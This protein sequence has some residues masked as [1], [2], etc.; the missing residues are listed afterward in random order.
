MRIILI[1]PPG[2]G[3]GTQAARLVR[4]YSIPAVSTGE[5]L[6]HAADQGSELGQTADSFMKRGQLVPDES[7]IAMVMERIA[8]PDCASGFLLDGF[9]RTLTQAEALH[10]S[11]QQAGIGVDSAVLIEVPDDLIMERIT[12]RRLDPQTG[13]IYHVKF[14]PPPPDV[15]PRLVQRKDDTEEACQARLVRYHAETEPIVAYYERQNLLCRVDGVGDPD[16]IGGRL[17]V[18]LTKKTE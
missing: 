1:G 13:T 16:R 6:R 5:M 4:T 9:P 17:M 11:L 14:D 15:V 7:V 3:K 12:G 10:E 8:Q 18:C 2:A